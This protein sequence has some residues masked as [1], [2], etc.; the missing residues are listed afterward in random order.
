VFLTTTTSP[1]RLSSSR[2]C[3]SCWSTCRPRCIW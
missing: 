2:A 1:S 3:R